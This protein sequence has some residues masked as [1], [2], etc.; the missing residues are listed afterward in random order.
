MAD[1]ILLQDLEEGE[2]NDIKPI[3]TKKDDGTLEIEMCNKKGVSDIRELIEV[4]FLKKNR[5]TLS[6][7]IF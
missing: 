1:V 4:F 6:L 3:I 2:T 7:G 5:I